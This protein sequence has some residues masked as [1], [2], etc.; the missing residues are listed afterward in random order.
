MDKAFRAIRNEFEIRNL[1]GL[2]E[3]DPTYKVYLVSAQ[4]IV[5]QNSDAIKGSINQ[6]LE[7][8]KKEGIKPD[9]SLS[10]EDAFPEQK[11]LLLELHDFLIK[12][13]EEWQDLE[14]PKI[15]LLTHHNYADVLFNYDSFIR[16]FYGYLLMGTGQGDA[17]NGAEL[18]KKRAVNVLGSSVAE[19][20]WIGDFFEAKPATMAR[21]LISDKEHDYESDTKTWELANQHGF[22]KEAWSF[23]RRYGNKV[24]EI[25]EDAA[26]Y[27]IEAFGGDAK[28]EGA[29]TARLTTL[30]T[31][32][33]LAGTYKTE[34]LEK[35]D[36]FRPVYKSVAILLAQDKRINS[37]ETFSNLFEEFAPQWDALPKLQLDHGEDNAFNRDDAFDTALGKGLQVVAQ[38]VSPSIDPNR[39]IDVMA[40]WQDRM[41]DLIRSRNWLV[42]EF[43]KGA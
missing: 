33:Y 25:A 31:F 34:D 12:S 6:I 17:Y 13:Q 43:D 11:K 39:L 18:Q 27:A 24:R 26:T 35:K 5:M 19:E 16:E 9:P 32:A 1:A 36:L 7:T 40:Y 30:L 20:K 3:R 21:I 28:S 22:T 14:P 10:P 41:S 38:K 8:H 29:E 23:Y 42:S 2:I 37:V 15:F 4:K